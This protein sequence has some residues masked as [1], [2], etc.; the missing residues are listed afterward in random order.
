M[1]LQCEIHYPN[2]EK[3]SMYIAIIEN[4]KVIVCE[5]LQ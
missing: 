4:N 1:D 3:H 2:Q 5:N